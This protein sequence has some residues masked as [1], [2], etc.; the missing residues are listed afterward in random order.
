M[1][2]Q[3]TQH[4]GFCPWCHGHIEL[5]GGRLLKAS[6]VDTRLGSDKRADV[7]YLRRAY[8]NDLGPNF[9]TSTDFNRATHG[10]VYALL[11]MLDRWNSQ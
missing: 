10:F 7:D 8:Q 9:V 3:M 2:A 11:S 1:D 5:T 4:F 6:G